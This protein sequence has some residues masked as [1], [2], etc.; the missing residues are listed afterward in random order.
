MLQVQTTDRH[1]SRIEAL[2]RSGLLTRSHKGEFEHLTTHVR[3]VLDVPVA[4]VTLVDEDRQVFAGH[5]GLPSPWDARGETPM[6]HSFCQHVVD[7]NA[8]LNVCDANLDPL[9]RDNHAIFDI[10]VVAYLGVPLALPD[11]EVVGALAAIDTAP[12]V[13]TDADERRLHS[14]ARTVEKEMAVRISEA[15]WRSLFEGLHEGFILGRVVRDEAGRIVDWLYEEVN[16]A[17]HDLTGVPHGSVVGR[18]IREVFPGI[19]DEWIDEFADVVRTG[20]P[21]RFTRQVGTLGRWYDGVAQAIGSDRFTVIFLE[22]TDRIEQERRQNA[23]LKLGDDLRNLSTIDDIVAAA[24]ECVASGI[25]ADRVGFGSVDERS[26]TVE[27][28][29]HWIAAGMTSIAGLHDFRSFGSF[30]DELKRGE[31]VAIADVETDCRTAGAAGAFSAI[32]IRSLLNLPILEAGRIVL[33][34]FAHRRNVLAWTESELRF[35]RQVGDRTQAAIGRLRAEEGQRVLN[36]EL[37]HRMKNSLAMV[38][39]IAT[40]TLRQARTMDEGREAIT[41][42]LSALARAQDILTRTD[43]TE[44][45]VREVVDAAMAPHRSSQVHIEAYDDRITLTAQQALGL[46]LAI[47]ELA[48]NAAKYGALSCLEGSVTMSWGETDK[49]FYFKWI[50][51]GGPTVAPPERRGFGSKLIERIV[52]SYFDGEGRLDFD[53]AG[54][55]FT[56]TGAP[57]AVETAA[58]A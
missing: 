20:T 15:R 2:R 33:V 39:A 43:F 58:Q 38:Q 22:V 7:R 44:A 56:L 47:H 35:V 14:I 13:W 3:D 53:P 31:T 24:S 48:T 1:S 57:K 4:I 52:A 50:E 6:T 37:A 36:Q 40:Q 46:S 34:V 55:R 18:T 11:G 30:I 27:I 29:P 9:V 42:R 21:A 41:S 23:L 51:E 5:S 25:E 10:G 28:R 19:E 32:Q 49:A 26:E 17:W 8:T 54:I 12:R 45:N 16:S